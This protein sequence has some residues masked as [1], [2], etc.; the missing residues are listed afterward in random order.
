M[1]FG[2]HTVVS[3]QRQ[4]TALNNKWIYE[5]INTWRVDDGNLQQC[6]YGR[7]KD[8]AMAVGNKYQEPDPYA[9]L[10]SSHMFP[11]LVIIT[12]TAEAMFTVIMVLM[13]IVHCDGNHDK[14]RKRELPCSPH[15]C[16]NAMAIKIMMDFYLPISH[17][18]L[19][20]LAQQ[21]CMLY[22]EC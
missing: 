12:I 10:R 14:F 7:R 20:V 11:S 8:W 2:N 5:Y 16:K 4:R 3:H 19:R 22:V 13:V 1:L 18:C 6:S 17:G 15:Y 9:R 21:N